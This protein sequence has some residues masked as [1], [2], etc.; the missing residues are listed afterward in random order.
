MSETTEG[1]LENKLNEPKQ[2]EKT[3][4][5]TAL[6]SAGTNSKKDDYTKFYGR[7]NARR[8]LQVENEYI[9]W[10]EKGRIQTIVNQL[11]HYLKF[12]QVEHDK[13][14]QEVNRLTEKNNE[15]IAGKPQ[16]KIDD[17]AK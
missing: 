2:P 5:H 3:D 7:R 6:A 13:L 14:D 16:E 10:H 11:V 8:F 12:L 17:S 1:L 9:N 15:L 4:T